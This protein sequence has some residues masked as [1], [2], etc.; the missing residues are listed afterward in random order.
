LFI[1]VLLVIFSIVNKRFVSLR[2]PT[3]HQV[4]CFALGVVLFAMVNNRL[5]Y[6]AN[7]IAELR[8]LATTPAPLIF[9]DDVSTACRSVVL[10]L[11]Q[12]EPSL[13]MTIDDI[14]SS[15]WMMQHCP[16]TNTAA[17]T[18]S[19]SSSSSALAAPSQPTAAPAAAASA[20]V[21]AASSSMSSAADVLIDLSDNSHNVVNNDNVNNNSMME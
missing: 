6:A 8:R 7:D 17:T 16:S 1:I 15:A 5:P 10:G 20:T 14:L 9:D 19:A 21:G 12:P 13:R 3:T 2:R 4:D 18:S 11:L